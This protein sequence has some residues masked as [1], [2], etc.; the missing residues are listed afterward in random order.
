M[1]GLAARGFAARPVLA[2]RWAAEAVSSLFAAGRR[3]EALDLADAVPGEGRRLALA[4]AGFDPA[5]AL[6]H[7]PIDDADLIAALSHASGQSGATPT[8]AQGRLASGHG[9][10]KDWAELF[11]SHGMAPVASGPEARLTLASA[12]ARAEAVDDADR[13]SVVMPMWNASAYV[14]VA[15]RSILDQG[16]RNLELIVVDDASTDGSIDTALAAAEGDLRL[17]I[18]RQDVRLGPYVARNRALQAATGRWVAFHDADEWAHP[19]RLRVQVSE[20]KRRGLAASAG[21][22]V[23]VDDEGAPRARGVWPIVRL[24]PSTLMIDRAAVLDG[25]GLMHEVG[26]GA[27]S[28]YWWR[29]SCLFGPQRVAFLPHLLTLGAW[30]QDSQTVS[31]ETGY[32]DGGVNPDRLAYWEAWNLWHLAARKD[33]AALKLGPGAAP[34]ETPSGLRVETLEARP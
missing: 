32:G 31:A 16:W 28:E 14:G 5:R 18:L 7:A 11:R 2:R 22:G 15:I 12:E 8:S 33:R 21:R 25:V 24:A 1:H 17:T 3:Q 9:V 4:L 26:S 6:D 29:M 13:I 23:R 20:M 30:R 19:D 34:F 10:T 27:D